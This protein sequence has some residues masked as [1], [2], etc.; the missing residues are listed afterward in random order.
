[1]PWGYGRPSIESRAD[2]GNGPG[3]KG[4]NSRPRPRRARWHQTRVAPDG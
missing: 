4:A 1:V 3:R 2:G